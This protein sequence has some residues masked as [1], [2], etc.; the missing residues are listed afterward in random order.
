MAYPRTSVFAGLRS[1][2]RFYVLGTA[3]AGSKLPFVVTPI[4]M[5]LDAELKLGGKSGCDVIM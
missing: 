1:S 4:K 3:Q 2:P 5:L